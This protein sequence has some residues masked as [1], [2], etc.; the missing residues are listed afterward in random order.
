MTT[1][2]TGTSDS[3]RFLVSRDTRQMAHSLADPP[4]RRL[5]A[6]SREEC[7]TLLGSVPVG[8]VVFTHHA[9]P[10]VLPVNFRLDGDAVMI[11]VAIGSV[12]AHAAEGA[13]LAFHADRIDAATRTGW[14]VT[15]VGRATEIT[16]AAERQRVADLPLETWV[17]DGRDHFVCI[18]AERIT[19][20]R[21]V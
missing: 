1:T 12:L 11:R 9:L 8:Q 5:V 13:V 10:E 7:L 14:S 17:G 4:S 3:D 20:R 21:L 2:E 15:V 18:P 19:G 16:D 6:L